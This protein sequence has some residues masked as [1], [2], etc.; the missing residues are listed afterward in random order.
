MFAKA[1]L[2]LT[3]GGYD[4]SCLNLILFCQANFEFIS[5]KLSAISSIPVDRLEVALGRATF[6]SD[7]SVFDVEE[8]MQW[9]SIP[10]DGEDE[11]PFHISDD[12]Y[13]LFYR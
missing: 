11:Q 3:L 8:K 2:Q 5:F 6:P 13:V 10:P 9:N 7:L 1:L 4:L 12:G